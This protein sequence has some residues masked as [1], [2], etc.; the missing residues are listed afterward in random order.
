MKNAWLYISTRLS[1]CLSQV[2]DQNK[3]PADTHVMGARTCVKELA[4]RNV[5]TPDG[6]ITMVVCRKN[7]LTEMC[8]STSSSLV[9]RVNK[10]SC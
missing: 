5:I 7:S 2:N 8:Y 6:N 3:V 9:S 4:K 10:E 1:H